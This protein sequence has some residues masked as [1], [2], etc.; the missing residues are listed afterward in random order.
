MLWNINFMKFIITD[1]NQL[2]K[3]LININE[4]IVIKFRNSNQKNPAA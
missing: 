1:K 2:Q 4:A 3:Y